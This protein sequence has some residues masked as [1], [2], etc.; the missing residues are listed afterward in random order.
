MHLP[1]FAARTNTSRKCATNTFHTRRHQRCRS[2]LRLKS[3][4]LSTRSRAAR[5]N[6]ITVCKLLSWRDVQTLVVSSRRAASHYR[7]RHVSHTAQ[8]IDQYDTINILE[9]KHRH[10]H[11]ESMPIGER[12]RSDTID[13]EK[14]LQ[15]EQARAHDFRPRASWPVLTFFAWCIFLGRLFAYLSVQL[16]LW[17]IFRITRIEWDVCYLTWQFT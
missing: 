1:F 3:T 9:P 5:P 14:T 15:E 13:A 2:S 16:S 6:D 10:S 7:K 11:A 4:K 17:V 8:S 12:P